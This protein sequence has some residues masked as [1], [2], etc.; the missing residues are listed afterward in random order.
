MCK[1]TASKNNFVVCVDN[2]LRGYVGSRGGQ[3]VE[4]DADLWERQPAEASGPE[5]G[6]SILDALNDDCLRTI[7]ESPTLQL[8]DL[9]AIANTCRRFRAIALRVFPSKYAAASEHT[10]A[11]M[12]LWQLDDCLRTFGPLITSLDVLGVQHSFT[13][14]V[15]RVALEHCKNLTTLKCGLNYADTMD[16][17][18][19]IMPQLH[20]L[21][22]TRRNVNVLD[23]FAADVEYPLRRLTVD[24]TDLLPE[25]VFARLRVTEQVNGVFR[26][27]P[28]LTDVGGVQ[29][30]F[31]K[32]PHLTEFGV[33]YGYPQNANEI[34]FIMNAMHAA[35]I[36]LAAIRVHGDPNESTRGHIVDG[37]QRFAGLVR[38]TIENVDGGYLLDIVRAHERLAHLEATHLERIGLARTL[39]E[40]RRLLELG[41]RLAT[42]RLRFVRLSLGDTYFAANRQ[43]DAGAL[44]AIDAIRRERN[45]KLQVSIVLYEST[46]EQLDVTQVCGGH[47]GGDDFRPHLFELHENC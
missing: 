26:D 19:A 30:V 9:T 24:S 45:V 46:V 41:V 34:E 33:W 42:V 35:H 37:I 3:I 12:P 38:L 22:I 21:H 14:V 32:M 11:R 28:D 16:A 15:T 25:F 43:L 47:V 40:V 44:D 31:A 17:M 39:A 36:E 6:A 27:Y 7:F 4:D 18:R 29:R 23:L 8:A 5:C 2:S 10:F 20:E 13:D 1:A